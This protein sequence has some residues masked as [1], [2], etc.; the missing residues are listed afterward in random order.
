MRAAVHQPNYL[1]WTG[2]FHKMANCDIFVLLDNVQYP[3]REYCNR[4]LVKT[5]QGAC[6][7]SLPV[8][9]NTIDQ[10]ISET[11]LFEPEK[12]LYRH[13][14]TLRHCYARAPYWKNIE[15][16]LEPL[17]EQPWEFLLSLNIELINALRNLLGISTPMILSSS[18]GDSPAAKSGRIIHICRQL[19]ANTYLSGK[20]AEAY[21]NSGEF[22]GAG[23]ELR[24]QD[25]VV[26]EYLQGKGDFIPGLSVLDL[27]AYEGPESRNIIT[28]SNR[29]ELFVH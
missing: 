12:N 18:L 25:Y 16:K 15:Q 11:R 13:W 17:Y 23:I 24:Y 7:M 8:V 6:W 10:K 9:K 19:G 1:P 2:F 27:F 3:R 26:P 5:S 21:N 22:T 29:K 14:K 20:G 4:T 28:N